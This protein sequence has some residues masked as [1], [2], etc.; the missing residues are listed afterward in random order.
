M[1]MTQD[2]MRE[3]AKDVILTWH[4]GFENTAIELAGTLPDFAQEQLANMIE[5]FTAK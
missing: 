5:G 3:I 2:E 1:K 4:A